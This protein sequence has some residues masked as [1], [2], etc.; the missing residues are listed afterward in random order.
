MLHASMHRPASHCAQTLYTWLRLWT[1]HMVGDAN[2]G[3]GPGQA[4][5]RNLGYMNEKF[6]NR[7]ICSKLPA[8]HAGMPKHSLIYCSET[9]GS[10]GY[11]IDRF[12][13]VWMQLSI[14]TNDT[15]AVDSNYRFKCIN[16]ST[17]RQQV[18][19]EWGEHQRSVNNF[20]SVNY[21]NWK[22]LCMV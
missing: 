17:V 13:R 8:E 18:K 11:E 1:L 10:I 12:Q 9:M 4:K 2:W 7:L 16:V 21:S 5:V 20:R 3:E 22:L 15:L 6:V 19:P 14:H